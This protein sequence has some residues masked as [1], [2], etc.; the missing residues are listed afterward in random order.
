MYMYVYVCTCMCVCVCVC[1]CALGCVHVYV[2]MHVCVTVCAHLH[3]YVFMYVCVFLH[4]FPKIL[5][6]DCN[7]SFGNTIIPA[8]KEIDTFAEITSCPEY[9]FPSELTAPM[10]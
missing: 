9:A 1:T 4:S 10:D 6:Q 8:V 2:C 7:R 5:S 3:A